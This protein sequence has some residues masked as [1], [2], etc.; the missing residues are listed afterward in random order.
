MIVRFSKLGVYQELF[1]LR[2]FYIAFTAALL[3]LL[4]Y[5]VDYGDHSTSF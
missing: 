2:D 4:S 5:I 3:A 1:K